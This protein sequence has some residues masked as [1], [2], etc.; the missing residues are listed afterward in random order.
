MGV[1]QQ[2]PLF[3]KLV[4]KYSPILAVAGQILDKKSVLVVGIGQEGRNEKVTC[5]V[6]A[7]KD[8]V[9][10]KTRNSQEA[11]QGDLKHSEWQ[12]WYRKDDG[13][14]DVGVGF[15]PGGIG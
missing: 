13:C 7:E 8:A 5:A 15:S 1:S 3:F 14:P 9:R 6:G 12:R 10:Q 2:A 11:K 4:M